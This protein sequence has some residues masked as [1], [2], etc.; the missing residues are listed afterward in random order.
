VQAYSLIWNF[1]F[2]VEKGLPDC[3]DLPVVDQD[4]DL[5]ARNYPVSV[6]SGTDE[7]VAVVHRMRHDYEDPD[8][9]RHHI[10][11]FPTLWL[12]AHPRPRIRHPLKKA[13]P[14]PSHPRSK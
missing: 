5:A 7:D 2:A 1:D 10:A 12:T 6:P 14:R 8:Y 11:Y 3:Q 13:H 4:H 9:L